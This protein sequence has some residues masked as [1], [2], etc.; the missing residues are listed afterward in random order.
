[1]TETP[2]E[3]TTG[4]NRE[5]VVCGQKWTGTEDETCPACAAP[6]L[7]KWQISTGQTTRAQ[8]LADL[9]EDISD[10]KTEADESHAGEPNCYGAG[11]DAGFLAGLERARM[12]M[13]GEDV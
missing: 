3:Q 12:L 10:A 2:R 7:Q 5:C 8:I 6:S 9:S 13:T 11:Y 1:M 4:W